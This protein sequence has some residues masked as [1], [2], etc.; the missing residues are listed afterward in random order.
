M[1]VDVLMCS[2]TCESQL[3]H[4]L[5]LPGALFPKVFSIS[6]MFDITTVKCL[7]YY[8]ISHPGE[9]CPL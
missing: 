6:I 5:S 1:A 3:Y 2:C 7:F 4:N 9:E 8:N